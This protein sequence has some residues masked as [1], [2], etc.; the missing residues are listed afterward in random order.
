M[1]AAIFMQSA[2]TVKLD[3]NHLPPLLFR[4]TATAI[5]TGR[6]GMCWYVW[7]SHFTDMSFSEDRNG[8]I[9]GWYGARRIRHISF[10]T[11]KATNLDEFLEG[12]NTTAPHRWA[13]F[14]VLL[15]AS[16]VMPPMMQQIR[17]KE[18]W[19]EATNWGTHSDKRC[20][21]LSLPT[22]NPSKWTGRTLQQWWRLFIQVSVKPVNPWPQHWRSMPDLWQVYE[23][24]L[25]IVWTESCNV[26][27][28][29]FSINL[30]RSFPNKKKVWASL[31]AV[32]PKG[33]S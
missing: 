5:F 2:S 13:T 23:E 14:L 29:L 11:V 8:S 21:W 31:S 4:P 18:R 9:Q 33:P 22:F 28:A 3:N 16:V 30:E 25:S 19:N 6:E 1:T 17:A 12:P 20:R 26:I 10:S 15:I 32:Q 24:I 7:A 27:H